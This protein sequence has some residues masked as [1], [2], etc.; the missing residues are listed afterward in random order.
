MTVRLAAHLVRFSR[1]AHLPV[2]VLL[3]A[4]LALGLTYSIVTPIFEGPDEPGHYV[5]IRYL[6]E[7]QGLPVQSFDRAQLAVA[8][9]HH[10][11]L[12]YALSAML[13]F[14]IDTSNA[15]DVFRPNPAFIWSGNGGEHNNLLHTAAEAFP[16][17]GASLAVHLAR[18]VSVLF[19]AVTVWGTHRLGMIITRSE[20][21]A[22][23]AAA[24]VAFNPQF[25]FITSVMNND[26]AATAFSTL[27]LVMMVALLCEGG[28]RRRA[29]WLGVWIALALLSKMSAL[30]LIPLA[31]LSMAVV[32]ARQRSW[33]VLGE[34]ALFTALPVAVFSGWWFVRNQILY[35]DPLG[36]QL[37]RTTWRHIDAPL[38]FSQ[39]ETLRQFVSMVHQSFWGRF[40]WMTIPLKSTIYDALGWLYVFAVIGAWVGT[41]WRRE[42]SLPRATTK[43][44]WTLMAAAVIAAVVWTANFAS[45]QGGSGMQGRYVFPA[46]SAIALLIVGGISAMF[47]DR[48][49]WIPVGGLASALAVLAIS[50][51]I[52]YIAPVYRYFTLPESAL[53]SIPHRL[54]GTFSPEIAL[55]GY[56]VESQPEGLRLTLYWRAQ[57]T[58]PNDYKVFIHALNADAQLCGQ[59]DALTQ[60]GAFPMSY[61]RAGDV[62]EDAHEVP[63]DPACCATGGC[64]LM[65]GLYRE[66]TGER[67]LYSVNGRPVS[68]HVEIQP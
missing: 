68:D 61:W 12:Y 22:L 43:W 45:L 51:P 44:A 63:I 5:Y 46:I 38:D 24:V 65:I 37:F 48:L 49:R 28:T 47:P 42:L 64:R 20:V 31:A 3:V 21:L 27:A 10:P 32:A 1:R 4:F 7:G 26:G 40:G 6:A 16:F 53:E 33:H 25:L 29:I 15:P 67:L 30:G 8:Y 52:Q 54:D 2:V 19:G 17:R 11:P 36:Y 62:I 50:V 39:P 9:G 57:G 13:T 14:W 23:G 55:A 60:D 41:A 58:P 35:G 56:R 59:R 18:V 34:L 66:D